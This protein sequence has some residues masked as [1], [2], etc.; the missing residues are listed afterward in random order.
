MQKIT[1]LTHYPDFYIC[2]EGKILNLISS[3]EE[4]NTYRCKECTKCPVN[5]KCVKKAEYKQLYRGKHEHL[6][7][8]NRAKLITDEGR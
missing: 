7:K 8:K 6:I 1:C 4:K 5:S 2:P 3:T